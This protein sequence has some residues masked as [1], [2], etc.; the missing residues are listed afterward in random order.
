MERESSFRLTE[1]E[2]KRKGESRVKNRRKSKMKMMMKA[3]KN[4][5][6]ERKSCLRLTQEGVRRRK[7]RTSARRKEQR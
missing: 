4:K 3:M 2:R 6:T 7:P 1:G 5:K